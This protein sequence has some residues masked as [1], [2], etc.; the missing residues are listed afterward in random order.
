MQRSLPMPAR[1]PARLGLLAVAMIATAA[2][3]TSPGAARDAFVAGGRS[4]QPVALGEAGR[5][6]ALDRAARTAQ[7]LGFPNGAR[8]VAVRLHDLW[9]GIVVDEVTTYDAAGRPMAI[10]RTTTDGHLRTAV[11]LGWSDA[12]GDLDG[13]AATRRAT[14]LLDAAGIRVAGRPLA[15]PDRS[16]RGWTI[17]WPRQKDGVPVR[18]D[19]TWVR[20]WP[21]GSLH[22]V[23]IA[24][25]PLA[26]ARSTPLPASD[27]RRRAEALVASWA[28]GGPAR[29][30][31]D[32]LAL[33]WIAPNDLFDAAHPDA[34]EVVRRLAWVVRVTPL[35]DLASRLRSVEL[36]IDAGDGRLLGGDVLE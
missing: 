17:A 26:P 35:G 27:A 20:L 3:G 32:G 15:A 11:R 33:A 24:D 5:Q 13:S 4:T 6:M 21:D 12:T 34:P 7:A 31:I 1:R 25:A 28:P 2:L 30:T 9:A 29:G 23:A 8:R 10:Q 18:G 19:G 14:S 22:S 16:G 36:F